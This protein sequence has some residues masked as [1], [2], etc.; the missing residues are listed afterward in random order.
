MF[1]TYCLDTYPNDS[2]VFI[3]NF[4]SITAEVKRRQKS[5]WGKKNLYKFLF[6]SYINS[7]VNR[8]FY[9]RSE[10]IYAFSCVKYCHMIFNRQNKIRNS[11]IWYSTK[12]PFFLFL[13]IK[14]TPWGGFTVVILSSTLDGWLSEENV[15]SIF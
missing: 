15:K 3:F 4:K 5:L 14:F 9:T 13:F 6:I 8:L 12:K 7:F 11:K 1:S 2:M 10:I